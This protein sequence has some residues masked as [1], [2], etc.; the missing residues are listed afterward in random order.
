MLIGAGTFP[1]GGAAGTWHVGPDGVGTDAAGFGTD[2][3]SP[4]ATVSY[5]IAQAAPGD[6]VVL[7]PGTHTQM[8]TLV[9]D[10]A[11][12]LEGGGRAATVLLF[13]SNFTAAVN[14]PAVTLAASQVTLQA[15]T[16]QRQN[17]LAAGAVIHVADVWPD[18]QALYDQI[19]IRD[20]DLVGGALGFLLNPRDITIEHCR[21]YGQDAADNL[22][23]LALEL[24]GFQ[25]RVCFRGNQIDGRLAGGLGG[26]RMRRAFQIEPRV[27]WERSA[28]EL[29]V[30]S[31]FIYNVREPFLW[32]HWVNPATDKVA[33]VFAHNTI[34]I[35][36]KTSCTFFAYGSG[37]N[38]LEHFKFSGVAFRDNVFAHVGGSACARADYQSRNF[39]RNFPVGGF[40]FENNLLYIG[41]Y[42]APVDS[43]FVPL[44]TDPDWSS[45]AE[46][47][48]S[49]QPAGLR[50]D[51]AAAATPFA[52]PEH[53][54]E[55]HALQPATAAGRAG[56]RAA[57]DGQNIG[58]WQLPSA[59][60]APGA[61]P[62]VRWPSD[63][64]LTY[65]PQAADALTPHSWQDLGDPCAGDGSIL[66]VRDPLPD[67]D[68]RFY[69]VVIVP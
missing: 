35:T 30:E 22:T 46:F 48:T 19:Q 27:G 64:N 17:Y 56:F 6:R 37:S 55:N 33:V 66:E 21:I 16:I 69:R 44:A 67:P 3:L 39:P 54:H 18:C 68:R 4:W 24:V 53:T 52:D 45:G 65:Q 50:F 51:P 38:G 29:C 32:N 14:V 62:G 43:L 7:L 61:P 36:E 41:P 15:L 31:N 12:H 23:A 8:A 42:T 5:A 25:G 1:S 11:V 26:I 28:G 34:S 13:P 47:D 58:A 20:V 59:R 2:A 49:G 10:K 9:I 63:G 40:T 60:L 57:T